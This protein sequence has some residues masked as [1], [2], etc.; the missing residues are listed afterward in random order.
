VF[1][2]VKVICA[3][4]G[5]PPHPPQSGRDE[6]GKCALDLRD[7]VLDLDLELDIDV[8]SEEGP[9]K[10]KRATKGKKK[11]NFSPGSESETILDPAFDSKDM[12]GV[13]GG[14]ED[15]GYTGEDD[16]DD[17][18]HE[19][20]YRP[21][22]D[23]PALTPGQEQVLAAYN[24]APTAAAAEDLRNSGL[25][26]MIVNEGASSSRK[27]GQSSLMATF[28][29][30]RQA[31]LA[32]FSMLSDAQKMRHS[33]VQ[34]RRGVSRK[35]EPASSDDD[36]DDRANDPAVP[37]KIDN[38][39]RSRRR[40][41]SSASP[42][43]RSGDEGRSRRPE[44]KKKTEGRK[45]RDKRASSSSA[46]PARK[47]GRSRKEKAKRQARREASP[48]S[49]SD[50]EKRKGRKHSVKDT[51][52]RAKNKSKKKEK[53]PAKKRA[54]RR[55]SSPSS[56]PSSSSSS[57]D[58]GRDRR[59]SKKSRRRKGH[60]PIPP[61]D[62]EF[63]S[64]GSD[65]PSDSG[66]SS[67]TARS[68]KKKKKKRKASKLDKNRVARPPVSYWLGKG[69][70]PTDAGKIAGGTEKLASEYSKI[71]FFLSVREIHM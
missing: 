49:S 3:S 4:P 28:N 51:S 36:D 12:S 23:E 50:R 1:T 41:A 21:P 14:D 17:G 10:S 26:D 44:K 71:F 8:M 67:D 61:T 65:S 53:K 7:T 15:N 56:S 66:D 52:G 13:C 29:K 2:R 5:N 70:D 24:A 22:E 64:S 19:D 37:R 9:R 11:K 39:G 16:I 34:A 57:S 62:S 60:S 25:G 32:A 18:G 58:R 40:R 33:N 6:S 69:R 55:S 43:D 48:S 47:D 63:F 20:D 68:K 54:R 31:Q 59:S 46:S 30:A 45:A 38:A 27:A 35:R 42:S